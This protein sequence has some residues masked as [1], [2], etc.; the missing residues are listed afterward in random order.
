MNSWSWLIFWNHLGELWKCRLKPHLDSV[1]QVLLGWDRGPYFSKCPRGDSC[2]KTGAGT[3]R[4]SWQVTRL[5][6]FVA[7][8]WGS[9]WVLNIPSSLGVQW[10]W[11]YYLRTVVEKMPG[12]TKLRGG[13]CGYDGL[14]Q[15]YLMWLYWEARRVNWLIRSKTPKPFP[16]VAL[17]IW[18]PKFIRST[19][20]AIVYSLLF[21][22]VS[23]KHG[24]IK[25]GFLPLLTPGLSWLSRV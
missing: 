11:W 25:N 1:N 6:A 13:L 2:V 7:V 24:F 20:V 22:V 12:S 23:G 16:S 15:G 18:S 3:G 21:V 14:I 4:K 5:P 10:L 8:S 17:K 19:R 9:G